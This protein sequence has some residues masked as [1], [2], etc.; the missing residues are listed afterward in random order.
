MFIQH[1]VDGLFDLGTLPPLK[2]LGEHITPD[3][4]N[5]LGNSNLKI[6]KKISF[7]KFWFVS[8]YPDPLLLT[9]LSAQ[10]AVR[11]LYRKELFFEEI[12]HV[13]AV[14][15]NQRERRENGLP[16]NVLGSLRP[17]WPY[18]RFARRFSF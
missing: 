3:F 9:G 11:N 2:D 13:R 15:N 18:Y 10:L 5:G 1:P 17:T 6:K 16:A 4:S 7:F 8:E 12:P 14:T